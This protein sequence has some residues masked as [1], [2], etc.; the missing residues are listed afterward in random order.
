M[1]RI[2]RLVFN[3]AL[4][5]TQVVPETAKSHSAG[6]QPTCGA[7]RP[8]RSV[9]TLAVASALLVTS[10][11]AL[12][13]PPGY[14]NGGTPGP[15]TGGYGGAGSSTQSTGGGFGGGPGG[16]TANHQAATVDAGSG[17]GS[18]GLNTSGGTAGTGGS[19][20]STESVDSTSS[21][22]VGNTSGGR[23]GDGTGTAGGGGGGA[24]VVFSTTE[25]SPG[26][27]VA[28]GAINGGDGGNGGAG[29]NV[30]G[31]YGGGGGGGGTGVYFGAFVNGT[32]DPDAVIVGGKG[33]AA[34]TG[35]SGGAGGT[36]VMLGSSA[37]VFSHG[38]ITGGDGGEAAN[39]NS[40]TNDGGV[41]VLI[42]GDN[43]YFNN[44]G[45]VAGGWTANHLTQNAAILVEGD[46]NYVRYSN[47]ATTSGDVR[48][49]GTNNSLQIDSFGLIGAT[50]STI[51]GFDIIRAFPD[52][53]WT[54]HG[55]VSNTADT[56]LQIDTGSRVSFD[57]LVLSGQ[58]PSSEPGL[59]MTGGGVAEIRNPFYS[60][61]TTVYSGTLVLHNSPNAAYVVNGGV[62]SGS[63]DD[64]SMTS[65]TG[66]GG[67]VTNYAN[68][69][70]SPSTDGAFAG[71]VS[72]S[73]L[74]KLGNGVQTFT[75]DVT[76]SMAIDGGVRIGDGQTTGT[77]NGDASG[78]GSL[79]FNRSDDVTYSGNASTALLSQLG[80]GTLILSGAN[81]ASLIDIDNGTLRADSDAALGH[82]IVS[83]FSGSTFA[84]GGSY[85]FANTFV[86]QGDATF[87]VADGT[88]GAL[89]GM[90]ANAGMHDMTKAGG[91]TLVID[92]ES[93]AS[94]TVV[95]G[96]TLVIGSTSGS[97][98]RMDGYVQS[99]VSG[100]T[101]GGFGTVDKDLIVIGGTVSPGMSQI[102]TLTVNGT[103]GVQNGQVAIDLGAPGTNDKIVVGQDAAF[104][105]AVVDVTDI[106]GMGAGV[107]RFLTFNGDLLF[108]GLTLGS[109]PVGQQLAL[110]YVEDDKAFDIVDSTNT[111]LNYWNA[112]GLASGTHAGGGSGTWSSTASVFSDAEGS[113]TGAMSPQPGFAVFGGAAGTV[114]VDNS[115]GNVSARGMQFLS[116]GYRMTGDT[117]TLVASDGDAPIIRVGDG[118]T[119]GRGTVATIDNTVA[120]TDG[121]VKTD[122]GTLVLNGNNTYSGGTWINGGTLAGSTDT[123][124]GTGDI[125]MAEGST[126]GFLADGMQVANRII[127]AGDPTID[128]ASGTSSTLTGAIV[129]GTS[130]GDI[131][132]TGGGTLRLTA[133]NTYTGGTQVAAGKLIVGDGATHGSLVGNVLVDNAGTL[134][135]DRSDDVAFAGNISGTGSVQKLGSNTLTL[136]GDSSAFSG[137]TSVE[138][139]VLNL[140]GSLGGALVL[141]Q[142]AVLTGSGSLGQ[143]TVASGT[144]MTPGGDDAIAAFD[145]AGNLV[146]A[147]GATYVVNTAADGNSDTVN[148]S[149]TAALGGAAVRSLQGSGTYKAN[150]R[151]TILTA[152]GG[153]QGAFAS[154]SS[155]LAFLTPT[156]S[157][158]PTHVYLDL[159]RNDVQ[160]A[161]LAQNANQAAV[162]AAVQSQSEGK[163]VYDAVVGL[164]AGVVPG[165]LG[166]LDGESLA[167]ARTALVDDARQVREAVQRHVLTAGGDGAWTSV[168]GHWGDRGGS[169][170]VDR[171]R[172]NGG[173]VLFGAD[174]DLGGIS[175]GVAAGTGDVTARSGSD[176]VQGHSRV[177]GLYAAAETGAWQWQAGVMYDWNRL[178]SHRSIT[179][180]GLAG[181][182]S[183]RYDADVAQGYIDGGYAFNFEHGSLTPF[184]NVARVQVDQD[185]VH[186]RNSDAA[187]EVR[188]QND[189]VTLGSAGLRG[190]LSVGEGISA[191]AT[192]AYQQAWGDVRPTSTQRFVTG[193]DSFTVVGAPVARH[194]ALADAGLTFAIARNMTVDASYHGLFGGGAKDQGARLGLTVKW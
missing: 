45:S 191:H 18:D 29:S 177:A 149:G 85:N 34:G 148:V 7:H 72:V 193:G 156:L 2:Y 158:D 169:A 21:I 176:S 65:L 14:S 181:R 143:V 105:N 184:V 146:F 106:G 185:A 179:V 136:T 78:T 4:G 116:S 123:A 47:D 145:V 37:Q 91:G 43:A 19:A 57:T 41:G 17:A 9:L 126:L 165:A 168:W 28:F 150:T 48:A 8:R 104:D 103:F 83:L 10:G 64:V 154:L 117:L 142:G 122:A 161:S 97:Q 192:L 162:A 164:D 94:R 173:G 20:G 93:Q 89:T 171:L 147:N 88:T 73:Q 152:N 132:K 112:D 159:T 82:G 151:Y 66:T 58:D 67:V 130:A 60:G 87:D 38:S 81:T 63:G 55:V 59:I 75:G 128:V 118:T 26:S 182:A 178:D 24:G 170:G 1:N 111:T 69:S 100:T 68:L 172:S 129:D 35:A 157:Y 102:G 139:G 109:T 84:F 92:G 144:R 131:V 61:M 125:T 166:Q 49:I 70:L 119:D 74:N 135:F 71:N 101:V 194:A 44:Y 51:A 23:G 42:A 46:N 13:A 140:A 114:T 30:D 31:S 153:V 121:L 96:G 77:F 40:G 180:Q 15:Q 52:S 6:A 22:G 167:S 187:L 90:L 124:F 36:G 32:I 113:A 25:A 50:D 188:S 53:N 27:G 134:A 174:R 80:T 39:A 79:A 76:A 160:F 138:G 163:A 95:T 189:G 183:A 99:I 127:V 54:F 16:A 86:L 3:R 115:A 108:N 98:A 11:M 175:L 62:L 5:V 107:Y 155:N 133:A 186:E 137:T 141:S 33:G 120:G 190:K 12:A 56:T 110:R